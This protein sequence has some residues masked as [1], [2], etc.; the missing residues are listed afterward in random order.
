MSANKTSSPGFSLDLCVFL[1]NLKHISKNL[2]IWYYCCNIVVHSHVILADLSTLQ[3]KKLKTK[4]IP[5]NAQNAEISK[6]RKL[7]T[8]FQKEATII[9]ELPNLEKKRS[10]TESE[11]T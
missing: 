2:W 11:T 1:P 4:T 7:S 10:E 9:S 5:R 8:A 3:N 6:R